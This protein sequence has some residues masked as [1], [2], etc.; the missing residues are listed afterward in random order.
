MDLK[1]PR[2][3]A[4]R[5]ALLALDQAGVDTADFAEGTL[6]PGRTPDGLMGVNAGVNVMLVAANPQVFE[7]LGVELPDDETWTWE[8]W[9]ALSAEITAKGDGIFGSSDPTLYDLGFWMWMRQKGKDLYTA[10]GLGFDAADAREFFEF[11]QRLETDGAVAPVGQSS[12][13]IV[14]PLADRLFTQGRTAMSVYWSNQVLSLET[15]SGADLQLLRF[16]S[17]TG[18]AADA[19]LFYNVS[20]MWSVPARSKNPEAAAAFVDFLVNDPRAADVLVAERGMPANTLLRARVTPELSPSDA[21]AAAYL[22]RVEP[23]LTPPSPAAP[24][25]LGDISLPQTRYLQDVRF[26]RSDPATAAE[27]YVAELTS[28]ILD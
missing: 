27:A 20:M 2:Q 8:E 14:A 7:S 3:Y 5:G 19:Q 1:Y 13:D 6:D 15:A 28:M 25:G 16:P 18:R 23:D 26:G 12:E 4:D 21:K 17:M 22:A 11:S 24:A 9:A 10:D